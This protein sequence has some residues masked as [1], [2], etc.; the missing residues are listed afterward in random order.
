MMA[1]FALSIKFPGKFFVNL[2]I[3]ITMFF[4]GGLIPTFLVMRDIGLFNTPWILILMGGVSVWNLMVA[5]T[6]ITSSIHSELI[7]AAFIDGA[8]YFKIFF[9]IVL[10]LSSTIIAVLCIFYAVGRWNDFFTGLVFIRDRNLLPL[11]TVL[12]EILA[13]LQ[14]NTAIIAEMF[15]DDD[16]GN[17]LERLRIASVVQFCAIVISSVPAIALYVVMQDYFKKGVMIGSIKG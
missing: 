7:E 13:T 5:R 4:S 11:Q 15:V 10:P 6:Y 2:F 8:D 3:I 17:M 14:V 9:R 1:A 12:R 16:L